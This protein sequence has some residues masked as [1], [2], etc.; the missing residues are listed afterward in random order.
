MRPGTRQA[1]QPGGETALTPATEGS[2]EAPEYYSVGRQFSSCPGGSASVISAFPEVSESPPALS[3]DTS[4]EKTVLQF[5]CD[6]MEA[7]PPPE[8][9][10]D[11]ERGENGPSP[12]SHT[13]PQRVHHRI[14]EPLRSYSLLDIQ[15]DAFTG[16]HEDDLESATGHCLRNLQSLFSFLLLCLGTS[17]LLHWPEMRSTSPILFYYILGSLVAELVLVLCL[18]C[19]MCLMTCLVGE[20]GAAYGSVMCGLLHRVAEGAT[21]YTLTGVGAYALYNFNELQDMLFQSEEHIQEKFNWLLVYVG[22]EVMI[23]LLYSL[24]TL[25]TLFGIFKFILVK[26]YAKLTG[27]GEVQFQQGDAPVIYASL[28]QYRRALPTMRNPVDLAF[29]RRHQPS[30]RGGV[31]KEHEGR[32]DLE[33]GVA[34]SYN[35]SATRNAQPLLGYRDN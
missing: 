33:M 1:G 14:E 30:P 26:I 16:I 24:Q 12:Y 34:T 18:G 28:D 35:Q 6:A 3:L 2:G 13:N 20:D 31:L 25:G 4:V 7:A 11:A 19:F 22:C 9:S 21:H 32:S 8:R 17:L 5:G 29:A 27:R 23:S 15:N 10:C